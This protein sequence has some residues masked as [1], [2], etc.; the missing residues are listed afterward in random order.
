MSENNQQTTVSEVDI[1]IDALFAGAPGADSITLPNDE[2]KKPSLFSNEKLDTSFLDNTDSE[3]SSD[4]STGEEETA[5]DIISDLD[6]EAAG[7]E[8]EEEVKKKAGRPR[9]D[10][11]GISEVFSKLIEDELLIPF[12]DEKP[13]EEYSAA[14]WKE[15]IEANFKEVENKVKSETPKEFFESLPEELQYAAQ[16]VMNGGSDLKGLFRA[17]STVEEYRDLD[18]RNEG[19]QEVIVREYLVATG[20]GNTEDIDEEIQNWKDL[21]RLEQQANKFKPKLD[22]MQEEVI[23]QKLAQQEQLQQQQQRASE[24]YMENV[25]NA[26]KPGEINGIKLDKKTQSQLYA[27]LVQPNY[28][29]ISG[30]STNLLGHLLEKYQFVEPNY[31]LISEAL[32]LLSDPDGYRNKIMDVGKTKAVESTVRQLKTE[33]SKRM[34]SSVA[35]EKETK[36]SRKISRPANI[37]KRF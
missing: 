15:L 2:E 27:G 12:D 9:K 26:L 1:D 30:K 8:E 17:L 31:S 32:W 11:V 14:D 20:F 25:Y 5:D 19:D 10:S 23:G 28:P 18:P 29:S 13:L 6:N 33:Q 16:Y 37:F 24:Q 34:S 22:K 3:G 4:E 7:E 35:D 21:G 36:P